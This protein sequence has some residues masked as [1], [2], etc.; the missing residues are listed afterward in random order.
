MN[1]IIKYTLKRKLESAKGG[2]AEELPETLWSYRTT[3]RTASGEISFAM[4]YGAKAMISVE[5]GIP[6][7]SVSGNREVG[8]GTLGPTWEG[9]YKIIEEIRPG[10][11]KLGDSEERETRHPWNVAHLRQYH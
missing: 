11:Y 8:I 1:K 3:S 10:T 6:S 7:P 5:V 9:P 4:A 2:W